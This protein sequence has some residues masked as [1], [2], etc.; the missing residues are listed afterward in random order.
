MENKKICIAKKIYSFEMAK[1]FVVITKII[2]VLLVL[3]GV[4]AIV[5]GSF[6]MGIFGVLFG[7]CMFLYS[8]IVKK[9]FKS[10][11]KRLI[12]KKG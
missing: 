1:T 5:F 2:A 7:V 4:L 10:R 6:V 3:E 11:Y 9:I 8:K 12:M